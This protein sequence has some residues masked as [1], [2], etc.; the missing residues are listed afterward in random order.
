MAAIDLG[1]M[2]AIEEPISRLHRDL[3]R[4]AQGRLPSQFRAVS[5][6]WFWKRLDPY[7]EGVHT[8][9]I[10]PDGAF[11]KL[12]FTMIE[13]KKPNTYLIDEMGISMIPIPQLLAT[14][15]Q[16]TPPSSDLL[17]VGDIDFSTTRQTA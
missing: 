6:D 7:F 14:G 4:H 11:C 15:E 12:P 1:N 5:R 10:S 2:S 17:V 9:L 16:D 3:Q 8:L 13:G